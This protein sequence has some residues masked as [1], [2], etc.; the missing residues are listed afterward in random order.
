MYYWLSAYSCAILSARIPDR[1]TA[2]FEP[3]RSMVLL[4]VGHVGCPLGL[5]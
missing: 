3:C 1:A 4:M 2:S 5:G